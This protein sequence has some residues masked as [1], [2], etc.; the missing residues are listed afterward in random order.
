MIESLADEI[1]KHHFMIE[2]VIA[3]ILRS[4]HFYSQAVY[5][6]KIKSP[7]EYSAGLVRMLEVPRSAFNP[8]ALAATCDAQGQELFAP[9]NVEGWLGGRLWINSGT[10]LE[11]GNWAA[12]LVWGRPENGL[13]SF[14]PLAWAASDQ[15]TPDR[16]AK[17]LRDLLVQDD[18]GNEARAVVAAAGHAGRADDLRKLI[19]LI[20]NCSEFQMA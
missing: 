19:Q 4:R 6:Q 2:P 8:L 3:V 10:L 12:D 9:P 20:V 18:L 5:R 15:L 17:A 13:S 1:R 14:D 7:V 16:T 11:R